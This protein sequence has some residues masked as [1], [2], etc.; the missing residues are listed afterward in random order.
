MGEKSLKAE[1]IAV[2]TELLLGQIANTNAQYLS[3]KLA[4]VGVDV[5]YHASV[6]D[7]ESRILDT[8]QIATSRSEI[9]IITGG[10]G[11]TNDDLTK[12]TVAKF[13]NLPLELDKH[14][15]SKIRDFFDKR[16]ISMCE[17]NQKQAYIIQGSHALAN[18]SGTAPGIYLESNNKTF[19]LL[20]GPPKELQPMFEN[21]ALPL[22]KESVLKDE[23]IIISETLRFFGIGESALEQK[24]ADIIKVQTNPTIASLCGDYE[25]TIRITAKATTKQAAMDLILPVK[26]NIIS[27]CKDYYYGD[28]NDTLI[29]ILHKYLLHNNYTISVAES[30]TGGLLSHKFTSLPGSSNY[31]LEGLVCYSN[32]AKIR[33]GVR[34]DTLIEH[35]AVSEDTAIQMAEMVRIRSKSDIAI[36]ITGVAGPDGGTAVTPVGLV[37]IG[38]S[39]NDTTYVKKLNFSGN[40]NE[41]CL[42]TVKQ[43]LFSL[44][45]H[46]EG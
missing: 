22:I 10:L 44:I 45:K 16:S 20:P 25:V 26:N 33:L 17:S 41:I 9:I 27:R 19:I 31:F 40:R 29:S 13:L 8:L 37:Y 34:Y 46:I 42:R 32:E 21:E 30:C 23:N 2:G 28:N 39:D 7:N 14:S 15:L 43:A 35:G 4:E 5:Y 38:I 12:E 18:N 36:S 6:G 24:I 11:P 3:S 1:I